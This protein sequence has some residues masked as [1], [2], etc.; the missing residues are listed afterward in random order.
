MSLVS[1]LATTAMPSRGITATPSG[2]A[3]TGTGA[4]ITPTGPSDSG[5]KVVDTGVSETSDAVLS[6][7]L[8]TTAKSR[9]VSTVTATG[10]EPTP[11]AWMTARSVTL[12]TERS[13]FCTSIR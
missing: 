5:E 1:L 9:S 11:T 2:A 12:D 4:P 6:T 7:L 8:V 3:P 13:G 10:E